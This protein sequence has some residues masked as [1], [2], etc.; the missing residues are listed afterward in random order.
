[1]QKFSEPCIS[2]PVYQKCPHLLYMFAGKSSDRHCKS[3]KAALSLIMFACKKDNSDNLYVCRNCSACSSLLEWDPCDIKSERKLSD[4]QREAVSQSLSPLCIQV[5]FFSICQPLFFSVLFL[6]SIL[7]SCRVSSSIRGLPS[8][9]AGSSVCVPW[10]LM[11]S[12]FTQD[13]AGVLH[14][15]VTQQVCGGG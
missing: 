15:E 12:S 11:L 5:S 6:S 14:G 4:I 9:P 1:M 13:M 8:A 3:V 2:L 10:F 7:P